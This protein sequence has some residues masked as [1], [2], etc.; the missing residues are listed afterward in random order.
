[1]SPTELTQA[2]E[3]EDAVVLAFAHEDAEGL[4]WKVTLLEGELANARW[5]QVVA[6][7]KFC[8]LSNM[9][10]DGV[11]QLVVSEMEHQEHFEELSLL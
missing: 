7:E 3:M 5:A 8:S 4:V 1:V 10:I 2:Q 9:S 11:R 6:E